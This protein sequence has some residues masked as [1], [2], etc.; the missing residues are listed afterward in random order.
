MNT[1]F[2]ADLLSFSKPA[3]INARG[4]LAEPLVNLLGNIPNYFQ[5]LK[6]LPL[7]TMYD[8]FIFCVTDE[9]DDS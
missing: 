5:T 3:E 1:G 6:I 4:V 7:L 8:Y 2:W 9:R